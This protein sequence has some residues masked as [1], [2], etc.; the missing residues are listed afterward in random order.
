MIHFKR[1]NLKSMIDRS[2]EV[3]RT[4]M[5][6]NTLYLLSFLESIIFPIPVDPLLAACVIGRPSKVLNITLL[7]VIASVMGGVLGWILGYFLG[8]GIEEFIE[9][10]PI[11]SLDDFNQVRKGFND[12]GLLLV[13]LGAF[14][15]L[16][17]K[18]IAIS[19]GASGVPLIIFIIGSIVGRGIRFLLVSL[20]AFYFGETAINFLKNRFGFFTILISLLLVLLLWL[21]H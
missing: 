1:V 3:A 20:I 19:S 4:R 5:A 17:Y 9:R 13:F 8:I 14:T 2:L 7:T 11:F 15:P 21:L 10:V 12:W 16:P 6:T 18:V